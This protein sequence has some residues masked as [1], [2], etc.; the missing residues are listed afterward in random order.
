MENPMNEVADRVG[1]NFDQLRER[2]GKR[3]R[4]LQSTV[5]QLVDEN[6]LGAVGIAFG[7]GYL[8]SGALFSRTTLKAAGVGGR[9]VVAGLMRQLVAGVGPG[10]LD[11]LIGNPEQSETEPRHDGGN[12]PST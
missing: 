2:L 5:H 1:A 9:L 11:A 10:L 8:L 12:R 7:V 6:P 4:E 3:A